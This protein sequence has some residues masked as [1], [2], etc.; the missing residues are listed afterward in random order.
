L[1]VVLYIIYIV[2]GH[3]KNLAIMILVP[4]NEKTACVILSGGSSSRMRMHKALL[5]ITEE[6][7]FLQHIVEVYQ[8]AGIDKIVVVKNSN[9]TVEDLQIDESRVIIVDNYFPD[10]GRLYS[11]Q[12][13]LNKLHNTD[14]C[15]IQNIDTPLV[16]V[17]LLENLYALRT[18]SDYV[19]PEYNNIGGHPIIVSSPIIRKIAVS[20]DYN[21]TLRDVLKLYSRQ[22]LITQDPNCILNINLPSDYNKVILRL[23]KT[24][25]FS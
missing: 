21:I 14:Y 25:L 1:H 17:D 19:S 2:G 8:Q 3:H 18:T 20:G 24:Q 11:L 22:I 9:I 7:N 5:K 13:G 15:F 16:T 6:H 23:N 12:L 10:R 4:K